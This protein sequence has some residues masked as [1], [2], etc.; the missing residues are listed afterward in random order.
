MK[1]F[2]PLLQSSENHDFVKQLLDKIAVVFRVIASSAVIKQD[3]QDT[4]VFTGV[5]HLQQFREYVKQVFGNND[6]CN[7][8][9]EMIMRR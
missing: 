7:E 5:D 2:V 1:D 8:E 3:L 4:S 6:V 9:L